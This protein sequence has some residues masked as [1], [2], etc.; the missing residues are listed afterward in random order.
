MDYIQETLGIKSI[1]KRWEG[2]TKLPYYLL[3]EYGFDVVT[4]GHQACIFLTPQGKLPT[5]SM[6]QKHLNQLKGYTDLPLVLEL[7]EITSRRKSAFIKA[8]IPFVVPG[9]QLYLPFIGAVLNEHTAPEARASNDTKL[10]PSAQMLLFAFLLGMNKPIYLSD[11]TKQC[12]LTPMSISRAASQLVQLGLVMR[13]NDG[14]RK[15]IL[16]EKKPSDLFELAKPWCINPVRKEVFI[17]RDEVMSDAFPAGLSA[18]SEVSMMN[19]PAVP[20]YGTTK[21]EKNFESASTD[22]VDGES[23]AAMQI[24]RYD[25][26]LVSQS[27][28]VDPLSLYMSLADS[29]DERIEQALDE[30]L[31]EVL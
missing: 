20:V 27:N 9:K 29:R 28:Q 26:R 12:R 8:R 21:N 15:F 23:S 3:N 25:P 22:L 30:L 2:Q 11:A 18:L 1:R 6:I 4:I 13:K 16:S 10:M 24:W 31:Q 17:N 19:P 7:P 14:V 5:V